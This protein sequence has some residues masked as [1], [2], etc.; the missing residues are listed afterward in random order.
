MELTT[1]V[2]ASLLL[3]EIDEERTKVY[4]DT[5]TEYI[6]KIRFTSLVGYLFPKLLTLPFNDVNEIIICCLIR[7]F[8]MGRAFE[9]TQKLEELCEK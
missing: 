4:C 9:Q 3:E 1:E 6:N 8:L 5:F 2:L 7:G